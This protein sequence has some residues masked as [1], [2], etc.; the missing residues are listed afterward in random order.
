MTFF[1]QEKKISS[2]T[3]LAA[4]GLAAPGAGVVLCP[5]R[6]LY[7]HRVRAGDVPLAGIGRAGGPTAGAA[8]ADADRADTA[9]RGPRGDPSDPG[10]APGQPAGGL[11]GPDKGA[12]TH[13]PPPAALERD[14]GLTARR[15]LRQFSFRQITL[16]TVGGLVAPLFLRLR[17]ARFWVF[18]ALC[19]G[20]FVALLLFLTLRTFDSRA[21]ENP[22]YTGSLRQ[23]PMIVALGRS[24]FLRAGALSDKLRTVAT[25]LNALYGRLGVAPGPSPEDAGEAAYPARVRHS[26]QCCGHEF[27][28]GTGGGL[29]RRR[30]HRHR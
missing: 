6:R 11:T 5:R 19:G 26:Q 3:A 10:G 2:D 29:P 9:R 28:P 24:V 18:S 15:D 13:P 20:G 25:N 1:A 7:G 17:R 27:R 4:P 22:A 12:G 21:F 23:A 16:G 14:F 30:R 8:W